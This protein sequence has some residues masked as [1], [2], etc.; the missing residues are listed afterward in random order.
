MLVDPLFFFEPFSKVNI[1]TLKINATQI[2]FN[3]LALHL[4]TPDVLN[5]TRRSQ[6][7]LLSNQ[8]SNK[9]TP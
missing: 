4:R 9:V 7:P 6:S 5:R 2:D 1:R 8:V 3:L